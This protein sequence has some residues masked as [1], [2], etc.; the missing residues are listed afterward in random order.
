MVE[1]VVVGVNG[2]DFNFAIENFLHVYDPGPKKQNTLF[3]MMFFI[4]QHSPIVHKRRVRQ[5]VII[6]SLRQEREA[7]TRVPMHGNHETHKHPNKSID[8]H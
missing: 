4:L 5:H 8:K 7:G 1:P 6:S 3:F 2:L